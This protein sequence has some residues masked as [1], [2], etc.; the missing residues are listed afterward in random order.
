M[1]AAFPPGP[2]AQE[3][4]PSERRAQFLKVLDRPRVPLDA[5][6]R[7]LGGRGGDVQTYFSYA[8]EAGQRVPGL[9]VKKAGWKGRR[10][11]VIVLHGRGGK[12][13]N[14]LP[15][16]EELVSYG[17]IGVAIDARYHGERAGSPQAYNEAIRRAFRTGEEHP[18]Y[19]DTVWDVLRL[20]DYLETRR[21]IDRRRIAVFGV[22]MGGLEALLAAAADT[23]IAVAVPCI[24]VQSFRWG[25]EHGHWRDASGAP[26]PMFREAAE[27]AGAGEVDAAF[28]R[29]FY[30]RVLPG[31]Y[32]E[33][34]TPQMLALIAPRPLMVVNGELDPA[35]PRASAEECVTAARRAYEVRGA[36]ERFE[37][38]LQPNTGHEVKPEARRA[39][40]AWLVRWLR[41]ERP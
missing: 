15:F 39:L 20:V 6:E 24:G 13:E 17:F 25:I 4:A 12:K 3:L 32:A 18:L 19:Y 14:T 8:S 37:F 30:D 31:I 5:E 23:R 21:D 40:L 38:I 2:A 22:S 34:D 9:L 27:E 41:P 11:A 33:F 28:V 10:P 36:Q 1:L 29:R 26:R 16:L 7:V 35:T